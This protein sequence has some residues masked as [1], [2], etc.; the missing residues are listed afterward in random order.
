MASKWWTRLD[1]WHTWKAP[2]VVVGQSSVIVP[3]GKVTC[4]GTGMVWAVEEDVVV[5]ALGRLL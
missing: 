5:T 1:S 2:F 4:L 3:R